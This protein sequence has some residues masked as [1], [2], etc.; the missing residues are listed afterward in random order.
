MAFMNSIFLSLAFLMFPVL[1]ASQSA[2]TSSTTT[3]LP[4]SHARVTCVAYNKDFTR[5]LY[6]S[7]DGTANLE[8]F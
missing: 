1:Q 3:S 6:G 5:V 4:R 8:K 7:T 2:L